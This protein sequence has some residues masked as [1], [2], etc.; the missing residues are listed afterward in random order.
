MDKQLIVT[1]HKRLINTALSNTAGT[2]NMAYRVL[3]SIKMKVTAGNRKAS[4][5][6]WCPQ[7]VDMHACIHSHTITVIN[8]LIGN[9]QVSDIIHK[10]FGQ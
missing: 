9:K 7:L 4:G 6:L 2:N 8:I 10:N 3:V 1:M 5:M